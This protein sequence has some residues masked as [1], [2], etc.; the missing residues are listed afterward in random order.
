MTAG[1]DSTFW[2]VI[3]TAA[4]VQSPYNSQTKVAAEK[5]MQGLTNIDGV[6]LL[7]ME[8]RTNNPVQYHNQV[9]NDISG[10]PNKGKRIQPNLLRHYST[11]WNVEVLSIPGL[12][13]AGHGS[14][15]DS[16]RYELIG[17]VNA[18][19]A[20]G[21]VEP[22]MLDVGV[23]RRKHG[24]GYETQALA[25]DRFRLELEREI[26]LHNA[27]LEPVKAGAVKRS[28][29]D[30]VTSS[31]KK[32]SILIRRYPREFQA[33]LYKGL[34]EAKGNGWQLLESFPW[35]A[36][37]IF[38]FG[39]RPARQARILV[40]QGAKTREI[41]EVVNV[42]MRFK[43][44]AAAHQ[45]RLSK[46]HDLLS[47]HLDVVSH[48]CPNKPADQGSWLSHIR[49]ARSSGSSEFAIWVAVHWSDLCDVE[50]DRSVLRSKICD[51][52]DWVRACV[53]QRIGSEGIDS[54]C[55]IINDDDLAT[56]IQRLCQSYTDLAEAGKPFNKEMSP[57]TVIKLSDEWHGRQ[58]E[59]AAAAV[60]FPQEWFEGGAVGDFRI[61]PVRSGTELNKYA[62][63]F[64][65]CATSY[66]HRIANG[67]CF[68]YVVFECDDIKAMLEIVMRGIGELKGPRN[69]EVSSELKTAVDTWWKNRKA[70]AKSQ[71]VEVAEAI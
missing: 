32:T 29:V 18:L 51:L 59:K 16:H 64:H 48:H 39:D 17:H 25:N 11:D 34:C 20:L 26:P 13:W 49:K 54:V 19:T 45:D 62:Y 30:S 53:V 70:P 7:K 43:R 14:Q 69:S 36:V 60:E 28:I 24:E 67:H 8:G 5:F 3:A 68:L 61:E 38:A 47:Q 46:V 40:R 42:P 44:F 63:H 10:P 33:D 66:A 22:R 2:M 50:P 4:G 41:A 15:D 37:R 58:A 71:S 56:D 23:S 31:L 12:E 21:C 52:R 9:V 1:K 65:N 27:T 35:L 57:Q 55:Q 6:Q